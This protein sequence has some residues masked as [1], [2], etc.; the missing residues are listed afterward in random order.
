MRRLRQLGDRRHRV[1]QPVRPDSPRVVQGRPV[2][3]ERPGVRQAGRVRAAVGPRPPRPGR[4]RR[5]VRARS[6]AHRARGGRWSAPGRQGGGDGVASHRQ[7]T[8]RPHRRRDLRR[9]APGGVGRP[10]RSASRSPCAQR[11]SPQH[12]DRPP[13]VERGAARRRRCPTRSQD[14]ADRR[15]VDR[16]APAIGVLRSRKRSSSVGVSAGA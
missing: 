14:I 15:S 2:G 12:P 5:S 6:R 4:R 16:A 1:F 10:R 11:A 7:A 3:H 8:L 9:R 13:R